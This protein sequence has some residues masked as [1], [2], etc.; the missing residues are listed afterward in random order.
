MIETHIHDVQTR[1]YGLQAYYAAAIADFVAADPV[2]VLGA[3]TSVGQFDLTGEQRNAWIAQLPILQSALRPYVGRGRIYLEY[4]IPRLGKR[5]DAIAV[6]DHVLFV[7]EFKVGE[8]RF[9][10][11]DQDQ[12]WDYA[13]D[14][15]NFHET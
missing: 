2:T 6:I 10:R 11:V 7:I 14:L 15:R 5:V 1:R 9:T 13:L 8:S 12:V 4:S 3:M